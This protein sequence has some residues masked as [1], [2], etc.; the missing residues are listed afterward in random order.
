MKRHA[1]QAALLSLLVLAGCA[2]K[3]KQA[4]QPLAPP[5]LATTPPAP[6]PIKLPEPKPEEANIPPFPKPTVKPPP[7]HHPHKPAT[8]AKAPAAAQTPQQQT[9][10]VTPEVSAIGQLSSGEASGARSETLQS[11]S[12]VEH[13]VNNIN[14]KLND[15]ERHTVAQIREFLKQARTAL[16]SGDTDGARTLALKARVLLGEL[17]Q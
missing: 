5:V 13:G 16:T 10:S 4:Q 14:R 8:T 3:H 6:A 2:H 11:I 12:D 1:R 7:P 17:N 15:Q 9:A